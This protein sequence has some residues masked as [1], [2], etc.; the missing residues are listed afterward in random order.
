MADDDQYTSVFMRMTASYAKPFAAGTFI[1]DNHL[2][3]NMFN[4]WTEGGFIAWMEVP[5]PK[6]GKTPLQ[7]FMDG[8]AQAAYSQRT[9][10]LWMDIMAGRPP[11][12]V[13][14][15]EEGKQPTAKDISNALD[16]ELLKHKV[17]CVLMPAD[18]FNTPLMEYL[19]QHPDWGVVFSTNKERMLVNIK[20]KTGEE[21]FVGMLEGTT[22]Y[23]DGVSQ[24]T[25]AAHTLL[26]LKDE[27]ARQ[28]GFEL[29]KRASRYS[30]PRCR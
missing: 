1:R 15:L 9:Y 6:T 26:L 20:T 21:L 14:I 22:K 5:D 13:P 3:G 2:K 7:L 16:A 10:D 25:S 23:P 17:W 18:Q 27:N 29:A 30:L 8:R 28:K 19:E 12:L 4:Y 11:T 24:A